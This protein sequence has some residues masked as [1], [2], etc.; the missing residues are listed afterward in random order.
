[1]DLS[2]W[3]LCCHSSCKKTLNKIVMGVIRKSKGVKQSG[4]IFH[5][6]PLYDQGVQCRC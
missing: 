6:I 4:H 3:N 2:H 5:N 1:M